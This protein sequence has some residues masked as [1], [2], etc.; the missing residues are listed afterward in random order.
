MRDI[1]LAMCIPTYNR[2]E[3]IQELVEKIAPRYWQYGFDLYI[4]DSSENTQTEQIVQT[5]IDRCEKLHYVKIDSKIH[6]NLK[7]YNIF[8]E[9]GEALEYDYLWVCTDAISWSDHVLDSIGK[10][11]QQG[12]DIVI[13][14]YRDMENLGDREYTDEN[15]LFLDCAWHMTL[16]GSTILKVSTMLQKVNWDE[17]IEKYMVPECINHSH[18]AFYFEKIKKLD[19]W[20][21]I[22]LSFSDKDMILSRLRRVSGWRKETFY[23]WCYCWPTMIN[24]LPDTYKNKKEV[25]KK[26]GINSQILSYWNLKDLRKENVLDKG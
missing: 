3:V 4:Y 14:N 9:F 13:P 17:L 1:K 10:C 26:H 19:H 16:Y 5:W 21:A 25:I 2:P 6:S 11:M 20:R 23:V 24:K 15:A 18:V 22:H 8:K 12:Y 7:V